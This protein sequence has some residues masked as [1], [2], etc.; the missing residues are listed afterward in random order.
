MQRGNT[1]S[2]SAPQSTRILVADDHAVLRQGLVLMIQ[3][4]TPHTVIGE[5]ANGEEA[6]ALLRQEQPD[7]AVVDQTMPR[8]KGLEVIAK[9]RAEGLGTRFVLLTMHKHPSL[10]EEARRV[11]AAACVLKDDAFE[12]LVGALAAALRGYF[13]TSRSLESGSNP[14]ATSTRLS[15][16][17]K[18][19][20]RSVIDGRTNKEIATQLA[21]SVKTVE[22][23]RERLMKKMGANSSADI[24]RIGIDMGI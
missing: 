12:E 4:R 21:I 2:T 15:P 10:A 23:H 24:V 1:Q 11:G 9:A 20:V 7:L 13:Y 14:E 17:E 8:T 22:T 6:L 3:T 18:E 16:R 19:I 5:A